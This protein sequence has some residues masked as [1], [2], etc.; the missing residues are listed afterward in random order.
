MTL[1]LIPARGGSRGIPRKNVRE[2]G[3]KPLIAW[4]IE[5][6]LAAKG[7]ERVV[8]STEDEEIAA[9]ARTWGAETPFMR[10]AELA[11]D[12]APGIAPVLHAVEQLPGHDSLV[13][14]QPTSPLRS[15]VQIDALLEFAAEH[16]ASSVVSVCEV[17]EHPAWMFRK[18]ADETLAPYAALK[19]AA[20]RQDLPSLYS[21]NGAM[22]WVRTDWLRATGSLVGEG[23]RGFVMDAESS[24]DID[25]MLDWRLAELLMTERQAVSNAS[26]AGK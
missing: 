20:R 6:A 8:V 12:T 1:A 4:T 11:S 17:E 22:Y 5:A 21:L 14:L 3:G 15:A 23:T 10:P 18:A 2:L 19:E 13:L 7:V 25:T 24:T 16:Q 26:E 9:I